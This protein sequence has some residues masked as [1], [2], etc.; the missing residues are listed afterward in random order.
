MSKKFFTDVDL[1]N[2]Q[3]LQLVL[4]N[5]TSYPSTPE[6]GNT[7]YHITINRVAYYAGA[8][9]GS[10][11]FGAPDGWIILDDSVVSLVNGL[12]I[13][14]SAVD[15]VHTISV[16]PGDI[17]HSALN[18]DET[19][20]NPHAVS[21]NEAIT[22]GN[23][24]V[25]NR[26]VS[27][28]AGIDANDAVNKSQ[29]DSAVSG[30]HWK[31]PVVAATT[32]PIALTAPGAS[33]D[34]VTLA[35]DDRVLVKDQTSVP[36]NGLYLFKGASSTMVRTD[37]MDEPGEFFN[38][39][40]TVLGGTNNA[41]IGY[42]QTEVIG[43]VGSDNVIWIQFSGVSLN[44]GDGMYRSGAVFNIGKKVGGG[45]Q[46][47]PDDIALQSSEVAGLGLKVG[48]TEHKLAVDVTD[49]S[50]TYVGNSIA[51]NLGGIQAK[52]INTDVAGNGLTGGNSVGSALAVALSVQPYT[53][54]VNTVAPVIS[55]VSGTGV[56]VDNVTIKH[57]NGQLYADFTGVGDVHK[58]TVSTTLTANTAKTITHSLGTDYV[59]VAVYNASEEIEV[60]VT[61][62]DSNNI[63]ITSSEALSVDIV[64]IG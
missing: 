43:T 1:R 33:I 55:E 7:F 4:E 41:G 62:V 52:H 53:I 49:N 51:A 14:I 37:G 32:G 24:A 44:A 26:I 47:N 22:V 58:Y 6:K 3:L 13:D 42:T 34:D 2:N 50:V 8:G 23:S 27:L 31:D 19:T 46:V 64:V 11:A 54:S 16:I 57:N 36:E 15:G 5:R 56:E 10:G 63:Q 61:T 39:A 12:A 21:L 17:L 18:N 29:L 60:D 45:I 48:D 20:N 40:V 59:E 25:G 35:V 9:Q 28:A 38:A 30:L